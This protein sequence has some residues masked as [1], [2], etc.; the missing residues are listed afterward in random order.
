LVGAA[1]CAAAAGARQ[2]PPSPC[3]AVPDLAAVVFDVSD[4]V[5]PSPARCPAFSLAEWEPSWPDTEH[6]AAVSAVR[7][8]IGLGEVYQVN[9]VGHSSAQ[10]S[11]DPGAALR[12]VASL[13]GA[14]YAGGLA[15]EGWAV[16]TA[17]PECLLNV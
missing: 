11:G 4:E 16:A 15:G 7:H 12:A 8:A 13:P 1:A 14:A 10:Y 9:V 2:G 5:R 6:A 17:S 3:R